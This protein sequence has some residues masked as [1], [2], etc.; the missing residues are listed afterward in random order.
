MIATDAAIAPLIE[1]LES[2][3]FPH[4]W[5]LAGPTGMGKRDAALAMARLLL[6]R[7]ADHPFDVTRAEDSI[8][9]KLLDAGNHPE[10]IHL[11]RLN[12]PSSGKADPQ[13]ANT[14][15]VDQIREMLKRLHFSRGLGA[16][17][18]VL[19]DAV[20]DLERG[21]SNALLKA[22]EE[23]PPQTVFLLL[24]HAP[25]QLLP[26]IRSRCRIVRFAPVPD[27]EILALVRARFPT[28]DE[29]ERQQIVRNA[30]GVPGRALDFGAGDGAEL[31]ALLAKIAE[32]GDRSNELRQAL[33]QSVT[34]ATRKA[35][36]AALV[37]LA[38]VEMARRVKA[39]PPAERQRALALW[40]RLQ[41]LVRE[42]GAP[43]ADAAMLAF[44]I[45][46]VFASLPGEAE[47]LA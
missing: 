23:P 13:M 40:D 20:D 37:E 24:S 26:T 34:G 21:G 9:A 47:A 29:R 19:I 3:R 5:I 46:S 25:G 31:A 8:A 36:F 12:K 44:A 7:D 6:T 28:M 42:G 4:G 11:Q 33:A 17:R 15:T 1:A 30:N 10:L 43:S 38:P 14:I 35:R 39:V 45:G 18:V 2:G 27:D 16:W 32:T 41:L 22:L